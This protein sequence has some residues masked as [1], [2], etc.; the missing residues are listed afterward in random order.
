MRDK[1][2]S[3][4]WRPWWDDLAIGDI[5]RVTNCG[6]RRTGG[7]V[8][9]GWSEAGRTV[10]I[11]GDG[12]DGPWVIRI[13]DIGVAL[14]SHDGVFSRRDDGDDV[15]ALEIYRLLD[16][17]YV[18]QQGPILPTVLE[19]GITDITSPI[20]LEQLSSALPGTFVEFISRSQRTREHIATVRIIKGL[21]RSLEQADILP[22]S[23]DLIVTRFRSWSEMTGHEMIMHSRLIA[24]S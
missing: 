8:F 20:P 5:F 7:K 18:L 3:D 6:E 9:L 17:A 23:G 14:G 10:A 13:D 24:A 1:F 19:S 22:Y 15:R 11:S 12:P 4:A 2:R 16:P 21:V